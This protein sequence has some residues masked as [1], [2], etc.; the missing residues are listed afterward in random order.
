MY[1]LYVLNH[2]LQIN[3]ALSNKEPLLLSLFRVGQQQMGKLSPEFSPRQVTSDSARSPS[4]TFDGG[5]EVNRSFLAA[6]L[7]I[8]WLEK[9][10]DILI[11]EV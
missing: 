7:G 6:R 1:F 11:E 4:F 9:H 5:G 8:V 2:V 3:G 10:F